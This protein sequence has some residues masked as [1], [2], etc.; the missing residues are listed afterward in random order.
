MYIILGCNDIVSVLAQNLSKSG[1]EIFIVA[2]DETT[3][4]RLKESYIHTLVANIHT[5]DLA[6]LPTKDTLAFILLQNNFKD[7]LIL[8]KRIK[9]SFP[10]K[11]ILS[12]ATN[13]GGF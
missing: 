12:I 5:L 6:S 1:A 7:N 9:N 11:F 2:S 13:E 4:I 3:L 8:V 10:D